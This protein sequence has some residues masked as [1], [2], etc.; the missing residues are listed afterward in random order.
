MII[1]ITFSD[2][3]QCGRGRRFL[4]KSVGFMMINIWGNQNC[5]D[6]SSIFE[7]CR[8]SVSNPR[9]RSSASCLTAILGRRS[10]R[11]STGSSSAPGAAPGQR[12]PNAGAHQ[13]P[14]ADRSRI[15]SMIGLWYPAPLQNDLTVWPARLIT[16]F[17]RRYD[18]NRYFGG[19][20]P[21]KEPSP[22]TR[23]CRRMALQMSRTT[24]AAS[25]LCMVTRPPLQPPLH[26]G[27]PHL[28]QDRTDGWK[29]ISEHPARC[30]PFIVAGRAR[31]PCPTRTWRSLLQNK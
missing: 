16:A 24:R 17:C 9:R 8:T 21:W 29:K 27:W 5:E 12:A 30:R 25:Y 19:L 7:Q 22:A 26:L 28:L 4:F 20:R 14:R 13:D 10:V 6:L 11:P 23:C 1:S 15:S 31:R 3:S 2:I 18:A